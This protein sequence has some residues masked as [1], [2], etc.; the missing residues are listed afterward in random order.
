MISLRTD[1]EFSGYNKKI[2]IVAFLVALLTV[3]IYFPALQN[4]FVNWDDELYVYENQY[5]QKIN[6]EFFRWMLTTTHAS[7]YWHPIT[8]LS[9]AIDYAI[10]GLNPL[11]HH[12]TSIIF[13]GLNTFLVVILII[14]LV[15]YGKYRSP[16]PTPPIKGG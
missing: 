12:L 6:I 1:P 10:W 9:H 15:S 13:H 3:L 5:I 11:G 16:S 8:W 7:R 14:R 2:W 4:D